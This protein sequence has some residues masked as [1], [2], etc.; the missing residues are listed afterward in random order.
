MQPYGFQA[1]P[2]H[3][4]AGTDTRKLM[5]IAIEY[6][7]TDKLPLRWALYTD[8]AALPFLIANR[9][10]KTREEAFRDAERLLLRMRKR[11]VRQR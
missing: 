8:E 7:E 5:R 4:Q 3:V 1:R 6:D 2:A 9:S 10:F 11:Y